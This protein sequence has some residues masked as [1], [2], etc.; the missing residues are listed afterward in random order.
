[1]EKINKTID[2]IVDIVSIYLF[3]MLFGT[4]L[5]QV[6]FRYIL[7]TP[8]IWS[9]ELSRYIFIWI[10]FLGWVLATRNRTHIKVN[11]VL[12]SLPTKIKFITSI[13][14]QFLIIIFSTSLIFLG[15]RMAKISINSP[16]ITLFF[17]FAYIYAVVPISAALIIF[18][19]IREL[20]ENFKKYKNIN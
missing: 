16:T 9:E 1:M 7:N 4:V 13:F 8:L 20:M 6:F 15:F 17:T 14:I 3:L 18:Y 10:S 2:K 11:I 12:D 19:S 5:L